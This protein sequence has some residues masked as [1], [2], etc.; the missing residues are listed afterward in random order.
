MKRPIKGVRDFPRIRIVRSKDDP[1]AEYFGPY[2]NTLPLK[3]ILKRIRKVFP[4]VSCNRR[5]V[6]VSE[7]P[8]K[9]DTN[10]SVPCLYYHLGLCNAPCASLESKKD[11]MK[12]FNNIK[13]FFKGEKVDILR[14]LEKEMGLYSKNM[15]YESAAVVRDKINDVKYVTRSVSIDNNVDDVV[16][17]L[18]KEEERE[19]AVR[20]FN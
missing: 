17:S 10:N 16:V 7:T 12:N 14:E 6:Q 3:N 19:N 18:L 4:Y 13:K 8:L 5:L 15:D 9:V 11:Y 20:T 2:P 1:K